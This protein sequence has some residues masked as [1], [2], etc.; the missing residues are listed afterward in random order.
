MNVVF[1]DTVGLIALWNASDQWH[2]S[3]EGA[4]RSIQQTYQGVITTPHVFFEC[5]NLASKTSFRSEVNALRQIL[6][7]REELV[8]DG[9][10]N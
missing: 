2:Q 7:A 10:R 3:A 8:A 6:L 4:Y 1:L 9:G 5:G